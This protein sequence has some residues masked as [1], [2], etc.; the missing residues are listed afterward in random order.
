MTDVFGVSFNAKPPLFWLPF[1]WSAGGDLFSA[2]FRH[3][4]LNAPGALEGLQFVANWRQRWHMAPTK[5]E[6]GDAAMSQWFLQQ[7]LAMMISGRWSVPVLR[8]QAHFSWDVAPLPVG[9]SGRSRVGIDGS[10]Y[11]ISARSPHPKAA[12]ALIRFLVSKPA[13][14]QVAA[15]GL[16]VPARR[17]VA[18]SGLL[19]QPGQPPAHG[20]VFLDAIADGVPTHTPPRWNEFS[21]ELQLAL[22]PLWDGQQSAPVAIQ[23]AMPRL[24]RLLE[25]SQ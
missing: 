16:I 8:E 5:A 18:E 9:P 17:D 2:D 3:C 15:S 13:V 14:T 23:T 4:T 1:L 19:S 22:E 20:R 10:G 25:T 24:Q 21:E 12:W 6:S 11:A 7:R